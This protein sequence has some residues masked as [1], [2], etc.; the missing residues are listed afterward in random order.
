[1]SNILIIRAVFYP[2]PVVSAKPLEDITY[3]LSLSHKVTVLA[4]KPSRP[5]SFDLLKDDLKESGFILINAD[6]YTCLESSSL[7]RLKES[8]SFG[9]ACNMYIT[10]N[11][12]DNIDSY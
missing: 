9:L 6:S 8:Y 12:K 2:E 5:Y 7:G 11:F 4:P 3:E 10:E 1:M